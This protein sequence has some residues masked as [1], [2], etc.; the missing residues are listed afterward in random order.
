[1]QGPEHRRNEDVLVIRIRRRCVLEDGMRWIEKIG[2]S[3]RKRI[4]VKYVNEFNEEEIGIDS[5]GLFKD[6]WTDLSSQVFNASYGLFSSTTSQYLYPSSAALNLYG[7][8]E[9]ERLF[10]FLGLVLGKAIYE[11]ITVQPQF[12]HFF[13]SFFTKYDFTALIDDLITLDMELYKNLMFLKQYEVTLWEQYQI[14]NN[15]EQYQIS[16]NSF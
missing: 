5:G 15:W 6:F 2:N 1:M 9:L 10:F 8:R 7:E 16:N 11:N 4:V 13:L 3:I 14:S 12:A